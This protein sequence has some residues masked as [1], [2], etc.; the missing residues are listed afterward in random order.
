MPIITHTSSPDKSFS[1]TRK[2][3][4]IV[5][6]FA[7]LYFAA[8]FLV[9]LCMGA[10]LAT[11]FLPVCKWLESKKVPRIIACLIC[12]LIIL[13]LLAGVV[14]MITWQI[15]S[16]ADD[17]ELIKERILQAVNTFQQYI[18]DRVGLSHE[19]QINI[20]KEQQ[21]S[22]SGMVT[23]I[24]GSLAGIFTDGVLMLVYLCLLLFYRRHIRD[25]ILKVCPPDKKEEIEQAVYK[26][27]RVSQQYLT[28]L[29]KMIVCL[30][31]MYAIG[32]SIA[33]VENA[34]FFAIL[35]GILE[36]IPFIGNI[37][38]TTLTLIAASI[39]GGESGMLLG[40]VITYGV[41]Q[42]IQGWVLETIIVGPQVKINPL[43]TILALVVGELLW[44]IPGVILAIPLIAMFKIFCDHIDTLKPYGFLF[45]ETT[46]DKRKQKPTTMIK[47]WISRI[48]GTK[49]P[50]PASR[51]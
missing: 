40:I 39:Q 38:G 49:T 47:Q 31:V 19:Q 1:F 16:L 5:L 9:P 42:F 26:A 6:V 11:L 36:I 15:S 48:F 14:L 22:A 45:G 23:A 50:D 25:F 43:F 20:L 27:A 13:I 41:V 30:W 24:A 17:A 32:F 44:G 3:F 4:S 8:E 10:V 46:S 2:L 34:I 28:G 51:H 35:C 18:Y 7:I 37:T 12:V 29:A 33:G 21:S